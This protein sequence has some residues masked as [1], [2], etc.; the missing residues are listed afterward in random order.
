MARKSKDTPRFAGRIEQ[1]EDRRVM[2]ADSAV[3]LLPPVEHFGAEVPP[4]VDQHVLSDPDFWIDSSQQ[5]DFEQLFSGSGLAGLTSASNAY[6]LTGAGQTVAVIDSGIAW[7]HF[8]LGGGFGSNYRVVGGWD[9]TEENDANPYD[10]G[11]SGS[12]GTHVSGIIGGSGSTYQGVAPGVDLVGLRVFNDA[13]QGFFS[14][15]ENALRWVH[16]N[17]NSFANPITAVNMSL[18]VSTWN[19]ATIPSWANLEDELAQLKADGIFI[20]VSAGNSYS[21]YNTA[22]LSYPASSS[23]VVPVM[24][25][26]G[27]GNMS[28]F[29]QRLGRAIGA[30]GQA[31][32][33]TVPD[34]AGNG[35]G[36][37]DDYA[38]MGG[39]SM[40]SP[41]IAGASVIIRQA[42]Q[43]VGM[44]NI[45][46]DTIY[47]HMMATADTFYDSAT[48]QNYKRINLGRAL[49]VLLNGS[50]PVDDYGSSAA[51]AY[52]LGTMSGAR[53]TNGAIETGSDV[54][55]FKFVAGVTGKVTFTAACSPGMAPAWQLWGATP[56]AGQSA[57]VL[58]FNVTAGQTYT[59][60]IGAQSGTGTYSLSS[61]IQ[62]TFSY[63]D[64]GS[65]GSNSIDNIGVSGEQWYRVTATRNG[66]L[67]VQGLFN[68][69]GGNVAIA[70]YNMSMQQVTA[71]SGG[72]GWARADLSTTAGTQFYVRVTGTN[73]DVDF[74]LANAV[75]VSGTTLNIFGT[76]GADTFTF[77]AGAS[78]LVGVNGVYYGFAAT[79]PL[80]YNIDGLAG[81]D[82]IVVTGSSATEAV[83]LRV[84]LTYVMGSNYTVNATNFETQ[85]FI[86][87]GGMDYAA[88]YDSAGSDTFTARP[89]YS[90]LTGTGYSQRVD[91]VDVVNAYSTTVGAG[92]TDRAYFYDSAGN[93]TFTGRSTASTLEG[94]GFR[95]IANGFDRCDAYGGGGTDTAY[96]YDTAGDDVFVGRPEYGALSGGGYYNLAQGFD[97]VEAI[98]TLGGRD[99][100][101]LY[102]SA[103]DDAYA[104]RPDY[105]YL[106][107]AGYYNLARGFDRVDGYASGGVDT[108]TM[109]DSTNPDVFV[110]RANYKQLYGWV[111]D[112][113]AWGFES[114]T[115]ASS[116]GRDQAWMYDSAGNDTFTATATDITARLG[117]NTTVATGFRDISVNATAGGVDHLDLK[118]VLTADSYFGRPTVGSLTRAGSRIDANY[119]DE[120]ALWLATGANPAIDNSS[121]DYLF[122]KVGG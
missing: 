106:S 122:S 49:D 37:A 67:T 26:D 88:L 22:G 63:A 7:D 103:G 101:S 79:T 8:A 30:P 1:L 91:D 108:A 33:S 50:A 53:T 5:Y 10:D 83:T 74:K 9:F 59:I 70:L 3:D 118:G 71:G 113:V 54:D 78:S 46:Q 61:T 25:V 28:S 13:G 16:D 27:Q 112:T 6:G 76:T 17:R 48:A 31:I 107:G 90:M 47:N 73:A 40:A 66:L 45:N 41:Y 34:Y 116:G 89:D 117:T 19:S 4:M 52:N 114:V 38:T 60:G 51:T 94:A 21:S 56:L 102:D 64:W 35:N 87:G 81:A 86:G 62:S 32:T 18:G 23:Y 11:P 84:G 55:C 14:W 2:S 99:L 93:D 12:H 58:S 15:I 96:L 104:S 119:F 98:A 42:M 69:A 82:S 80:M 43:S 36:V 24:S 72:S 77:A 109:Y 111:F 29:S 120:I 95:N 57:N 75:S 39:T 68:P 115:A 65:V 97:R 85:Q 110:S 44:T 20:A 105:S 92:Q 100:A 121:L